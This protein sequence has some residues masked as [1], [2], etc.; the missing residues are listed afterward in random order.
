[1]LCTHAPGLRY[2]LRIGIVGHVPVTA[3]STL[4]DVSCACKL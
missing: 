4:S 1:M 3:L 2:G